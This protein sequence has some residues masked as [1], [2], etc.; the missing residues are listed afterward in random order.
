[1][2]T[3]HAHDFA[4]L[5]SALALFHTKRLALRPAAVADGW[6]LWGATRN[7]SFNDGLLWAQPKDDSQVL[8]RMDAIVTACNRGRLSAVSAMVK[9]TGQWAA[10]FRLLPHAADPSKIELGIWTHTDFW[11]GRVSME[12]TR[13]CI[14][15]AFMVT[16]VQTLVGAATHANRSSCTLMRLCGM[17]PKRTVSRRHEHLPNVELVE[18]EITRAHWKQLPWARS[19]FDVTPVLSASSLF[20]SGTAQVMGLPRSMPHADE[21]PGQATVPAGLGQG[22]GIEMSIDLGA[23]SLRRAA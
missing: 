16:N 8:E 22:L 20:E 10:L 13:A 12:L 19:A 9:E 1:M 18:H 2:H 3:Q 21:Q 5:T 14:S 7:P 11:H 17:D 4:E 15:A 23:A 6:P